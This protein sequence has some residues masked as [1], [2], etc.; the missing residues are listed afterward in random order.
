MSKNWSEA[1][2]ISHLHQETELAFVQMYRRYYTATR[3]YVMQ[4]NGQAADAEDVFQE[5]LFSLVMQLRK[6]G[7]VIHTS[8]KAYLQILVRNIWLKRLRDKKEVS[9][10]N[11]EDG[12]DT[13]P[14]LET[15][16]A[17]EQQLEILENV[18]HKELKD[19]CREILLEYYYKKNQLKEIAVRLQLTEQFIRT[20]KHR[21]MEY[22][23]NAF[24][25][26]GLEN[27]K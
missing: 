2:L 21:C 26:A 13:N 23:A 6:D 24:K 7:F 19:D 8:L 9:T 22:L 3:Y 1:E 17:R 4:N 5:A 20:K 11:Q 18:L 10:E 16:L 25:K 14:D 12:E 15:K 27:K